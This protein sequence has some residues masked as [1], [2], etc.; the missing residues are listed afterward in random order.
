MLFS[1]DDVCMN[2]DELIESVVGALHRLESRATD[3]DVAGRQLSVDS[4]P[5]RSLNGTTLRF[6]SDVSRAYIKV[7]VDR[8]SGEMGEITYFLPPPVATRVI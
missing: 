5:R 7:T 8:T 2:D 3:G 6:E 1:L 4:L